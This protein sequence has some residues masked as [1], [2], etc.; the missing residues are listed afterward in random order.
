MLDL[1][2]VHVSRADWP[3]Q[4]GGATPS[5]RENDKNHPAFIRLA[6]SFE[7]PLGLRVAL[8][9]Q[10]CHPAAKQCLDSHRGN[11]VFPAFGAIALIPI[12]TRKIHSSPKNA[13]Y[14]NVYTNA[15]CRRFLALKAG[16]ASPSQ[17]F[18]AL[19]HLV[20]D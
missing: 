8:V 14:T 19:G 7:A 4:Q 13:W 5:Q 2:L 20:S 9:G 3:D 15:T 17:T 10:D 6:D 16:S 11:S 18:A 1:L 12:E